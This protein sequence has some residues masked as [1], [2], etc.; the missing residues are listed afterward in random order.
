ML[1]RALRKN[2][3]AAMVIFDVGFFKQLRTGWWALL[4]RSRCGF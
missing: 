1:Q 2:S 3:Q 4:R